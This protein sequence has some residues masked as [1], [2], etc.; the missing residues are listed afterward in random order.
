[1]C[2]RGVLIGS[3]NQAHT[4]HF[5][6]VRTEGVFRL[7][8]MNECVRVGA[9]MSSGVCVRKLGYTPPYSHY[10]SNF[11]SLTSPPEYAQDPSTAEVELLSLL[12]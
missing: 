9:G 8:S 10:R 5:P 4:Y 1:M 2:E 3:M 7:V 11:H 6:N 12:E